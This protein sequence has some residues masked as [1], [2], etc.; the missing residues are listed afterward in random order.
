M[1]DE[2][3]ADLE[4]NVLQARGGITSKHVAPPKPPPKVFGAPPKL[5][6]KTS[7][8]LTKKRKIL[9][10][11]KPPPKPSPKQPPIFFFGPAETAAEFLFGPA[12]TAAE[13]F[14]GP[15]ETAAEF[16]WG[17]AEVTAETVAEFFSRKT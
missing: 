11:P 17:A 9:A 15:A 5:L 4:Q 2:S 6:P 8:K 10:P 7:P 13:F 16:F 14:F 1:S 3:L 12:E